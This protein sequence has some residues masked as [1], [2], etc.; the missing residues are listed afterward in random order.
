MAT[1]SR[2]T[3]AMAITTTIG[4]SLMVIVAVVF[5]LGWAVGG[6]TAGSRSLHALDEALRLAT[7]MR[8]QLGLAVHLDAIEK[9]YNADVAGAFESSVRDVVDANGQLHLIGGSGALDAFPELQHAIT[10]MSSG[11]DQALA[12][13]RAGDNAAAAATTSTI[14]DPAFRLFTEEASEERSTVLSE[15]TDADEL[16]AR[17]GE[18]ARF[19]LVLI[20]PAGLVLVYRE[21]TTRQ[22]RARE[23]EVRLTA[24]RELAKARDEF[25]AN[26]SHELRTPLTAIYGLGQLL[27]EDET[28]PES[29]REMISMMNGE[30]SDLSR[31][32]ED[33][34]T[35]ARLA[36]GQLRF[37]P[38]DVATAVEADTIAQ[39]FVHSGADISISVE[40]ANVWADRLRQRQVLRNLISNAVKYGG[41]SIS[42]EGE[43]D[44]RFFRWTVA[45]NGPG[46]PAELEQRLFQRFVHTLTFRQAVA[47]G[48]GLGLSIVKSLV[49]GMGGSVGYERV[50][51]WTRFVV[52]IPLVR[53]VSAETFR[54]V[55]VP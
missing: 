52:R 12:E 51:G 49:E 32:V 21:I 44:G 45:D 8:A 28:L 1:K 40:D 10:D 43:V 34:L 26:A 48:V 29:A 6:V 22:L 50:D 16:S 3:R 17:L 33:L 31:M 55:A 24:E 53:G 18:T 47:G 13:L 46:V 14:I 27:E 23:L 4:V 54:E 38:E 25:V 30:A 19:L 2:S 41:G 36:A 39:P 37:E 5:T 20:I 7:V 9:N 35:T 11:A 15:I 42:L